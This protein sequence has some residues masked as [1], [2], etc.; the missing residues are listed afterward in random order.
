MMTMNCVWLGL[1]INSNSSLDKCKQSF[2]PKLT[3]NS[4]EFQLGC[5]KK[6][7]IYLVSDHNFINYSIKHTMIKL[8]YPLDQFQWLNCLGS[9]RFRIV[10]KRINVGFI[11]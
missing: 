5:M 8:V 7:F 10:E 2:I 9:M 6:M 11:F 3:F 4:V 1:F